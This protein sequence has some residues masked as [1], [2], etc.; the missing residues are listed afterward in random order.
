[1]NGFPESCPV[2]QL[3]SD[4]V[5][6][7]PGSILA[8][9]HPPRKTTGMTKIATVSY[10]N[11]LPLIAGLE[12]ERDI[13]LSRRVPS[14]LLATLEDQDAD[15]ALC[16][17]IDFQTS[18]TA[19]EIVP[20]GAIGCNGAALTVKLFSRLPIS[21]L[22]RIVVDGESHTS[23]ALLQIVLHEMF[24]RRP[25]LVAATHST[26]NADAEALLL[27][28]DKVIHSTPDP[29]VY[30]HQVDLGD[31]WKK[32]SGT[33]FVFA[34]WMTRSGIDLGG[35]PDLLSSIRDD[36]RALLPELAAQNAAANG[37]PED[38]AVSYLSRKLRYELGQPELAGIEDFWRRCY[39]LGIIDELRPMR[40][41]GRKS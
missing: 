33:P 23:V 38:L 29:S 1:M 25:P 17:V 37:W 35:V 20:S 40:L 19:L 27:I 18:S 14:E 21:Q 11:A 10:L 26:E 39:E 16:P 8:P 24:Q 36:N 32:I 28:G 9:A 22:Q 7:S 3:R 30:S 5:L 41:Y 12:N 15:L 2:I 13:T 4:R 31:A 34:T 6:H